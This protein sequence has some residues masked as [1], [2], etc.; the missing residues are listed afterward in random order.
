[1]KITLDAQPKEI[2]ALVLELQGQPEE[3]KITAPLISCTQFTK[4]NSNDFIKEYKE[5]IKK[6]FV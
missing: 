6:C 5:L 1:M 2:A 4:G 3:I